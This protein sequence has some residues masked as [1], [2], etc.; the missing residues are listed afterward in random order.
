MFL[1]RRG[2]VLAASAV[3]PKCGFTNQ[4]GVAFCVNC[5]SS[6]AA[7]G[8]ATRAAPPTGISP[9]G[10]YPASPGYSPYA[11]GPS[12]LVTDRRRQVE[13]MKWALL[14]ALIGSLIYW[15]PFFLNIVG[16]VLF[17][18]AA[19]LAILG[20]KAFGSA[21]SR[22]VILSVVVFIV[23][24]VIAVGGAVVAGF[25]A[26]FSI[27]PSPTQAQFAAAVRDGLTNG[28]I[29]ASIGTMVYLVSAVLFTYAL[30]KKPGR[31]VLW[32]GYAAA[33]GVQL[34][35]LLVILPSIPSIAD[36]AASVVFSGGQYDPTKIGRAFDVPTSPLSLL[37]VVP[38][39]LFAAANYLAWS[40][41]NK[42]EIPP[43]LTPPGIP[44]GM[45]APSPPAP[46]INP[47]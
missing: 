21:H 15:I 23:G 29:V 30:Q 33:L 1:A 36:H 45:G 19:I 10:T 12:P 2:S 41:I 35:T 27:G 4:P 14:L 5:G 22:N 9:V 13:R 11:Y 18:V 6:M 38:A 42:G 20:R 40:R 31:I 17:I 37:S 39:L 3:C 28:L 7:A 8:P 43:S 24:V 34:A 32:I 26:V 46:P 44:A 16:F 47:I 25:T